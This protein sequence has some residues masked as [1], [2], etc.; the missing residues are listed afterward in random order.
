MHVNVWAPYPIHPRPCFGAP[1]HDCINC[2]YRESLRIM[3]ASGPV[4]LLRLVLRRR[5]WRKGA[6]G[7]AWFG[8][9]F[10]GGGSLMYTGC[11]IWNM[12]YAFLKVELNVLQKWYIN[13]PFHKVFL[14]RMLH[15]FMFMCLWHPMLVSWFHKYVY[16]YSHCS[17]GRSSWSSLFSLSCHPTRDEIK[18]KTHALQQPY[19]LSW[20]EHLQFLWIHAF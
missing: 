12:K 13:Q 14:C 2:C 7:T 16:L 20:R 4:Y 10:C 8:L 18:C 11:V 17:R 15:G 6:T 19:S 1:K 5:N 9:K 3:V